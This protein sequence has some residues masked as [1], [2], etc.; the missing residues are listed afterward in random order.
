MRR[1]RDLNELDDKVDVVG[2]S[3]PDLKPVGRTTSTKLHT[4]IASQSSRSESDLGPR[5]TQVDDV[6]LIEVKD[7]FSVDPVA[8]ARAER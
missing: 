6:I 1:G 2:S 3:E 5:Q 8:D 7:L 4:R